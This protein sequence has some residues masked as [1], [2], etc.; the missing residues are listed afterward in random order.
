[1]TDTT[2]TIEPFYPHRP[3]NGGNPEIFGFGFGY[4]A[5]G[6]VVETKLDGNRVI[7][8]LPTG[9]VYNRKGAL[10]SSDHLIRAS[11][12]KLQARMKPWASTLGKDGNRLFEWV[13][14][15]AL[16]NKGHDAGA[17]SLVVIDVV[18]AGNLDDRAHFFHHI[19]PFPLTGVAAP[20]SLYRMPRV[21]LRKGKQLWNRI[22][23]SGDRLY[24][25]VILKRRNSPYVANWTNAAKESSSWV[26]FRFR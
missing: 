23:R 18:T 22:V 15:E 21:P 20:D 26:K 7:V 13:D 10:Y 24:E 9:V 12:K 5:E 25:G 2:P 1:M 3:I 4:D 6:W 16:V 19:K 17:G 14:C 8:H 11:V